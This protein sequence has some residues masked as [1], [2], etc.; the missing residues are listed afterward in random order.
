MHVQSQ[1]SIAFQQILDRGYALL[2]LNDEQ[3]DRLAR[4]LDT[5]R[6]FF[7]LP[8]NRK[9][10]HA[11]ADMNHGYRPLG[12][13]FSITP[14]RPD[15]NECFTIWHDRLDLIPHSADLPELTEAWGRWRESLVEMVDGIL[16]ELAR[17]FG[18]DR[19]PDF[20]SAS[21]LQMNAYTESFS[22]DR[23]LL[24]DPHED[25]HMITIQHA[26][27]PGLEVVVDGV[28]RPVATDPRQVLVMPGSVLTDLSGGRISP[29]YHQVR[30]HQHTGRISLMYFVN[31]SLREPVYSWLDEAGTV[32]LREKVR[33]NPS[34]FG[35]ADVPAL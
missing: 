23:D 29:L 13:E 24:Q 4:A 7:A 19:S 34:M 2:D 12:R 11:S 26:T 35:L 9:T 14:D 15:L 32:D 10:Q 31:P 6:A 16:A 27:A 25:G 33:S 20:R 17:H 1:Q 18:S 28:G 30:N 5:G 21:Y 3:A 22:Q 8:A